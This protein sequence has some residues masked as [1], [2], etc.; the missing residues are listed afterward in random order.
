MIIVMHNLDHTY[1]VNYVLRNPLSIFIAIS[2]TN[3]LS[4]LSIYYL[5]IDS[6]K[7]DKFLT[8]L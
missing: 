1:G 6:N 2:Q 5:K 3:R 7:N 8:D 4:R